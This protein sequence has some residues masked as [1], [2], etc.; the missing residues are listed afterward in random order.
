MTPVAGFRF[1]FRVVEAWM[2][3]GSSLDAR[4]DRAG[5]S[6]GIRSGQASDHLAIGPHPEPR[7]D[8]GHRSNGE[9]TAEVAPH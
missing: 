5:W 7:I 1:W 3:P 9:S 8:P 2:R 4:L 6:A